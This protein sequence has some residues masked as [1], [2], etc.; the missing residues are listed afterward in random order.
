MIDKLPPSTPSENRQLQPAF[1][2]HCA[3]YL[4]TKS[5][6]TKILKARQSFI[7]QRESVRPCSIFPY[8]SLTQERR[9]IS[10]FHISGLRFQLQATAEKLSHATENSYSK[11]ISWMR[12]LWK[13]LPVTSPFGKQKSDLKSW[14]ELLRRSTR[15]FLHIHPPN[16]H[17]KSTRPLICGQVFQEQGKFPLAFPF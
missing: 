6:P 3:L 5:Q 10:F 15:K 13:S 7:E 12:G 14:L 9:R 16:E 8:K 11:S 1:L 4:L 2:S 17:D